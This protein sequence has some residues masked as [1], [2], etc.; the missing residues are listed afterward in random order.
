V[1]EL[2]KNLTAYDAVYVALAE[3]LGIPLITCGAS[4]ARAPGHNARIDVV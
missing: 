2:H 1:W 3:A 4:I